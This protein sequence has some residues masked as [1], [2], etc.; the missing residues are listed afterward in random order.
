MERDILDDAVALVE[1][2][3][4]R[5][6]LAHRSDARLINAWRNGGVGNHRLR[7]I[8]LVTAPP[9]GG[10]SERHRENRCGLPA[11]AYSGIQGS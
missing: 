4:D 2:A 7:R 1:D 9:T 8:L 6:A 3:E 10:N 11:H 5:D